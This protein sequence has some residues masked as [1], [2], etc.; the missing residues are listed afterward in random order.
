MQY[1]WGSTVKKAGRGPCSYRLSLSVS[2][3][4]TKKFPLHG[5]I[6]DEEHGKAQ[7]TWTY[8][9]HRYV[10][11]YLITWPR[12]RKSYYNG[13]TMLNQ[14]STNLEFHK[15]EE[16]ILM[17][18]KHNLHL[19]LPCIKHCICYKEGICVS[20]NHKAHKGKGLI[21]THPPCVQ[22]WQQP[23]LIAGKSIDQIRIS[24]Q[25]IDHPFYDG[26]RS[27][28]DWEYCTDID[29]RDDSYYI[30]PNNCSCN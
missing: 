19:M 11:Y 18:D 7:Q 2:L 14:Y 22:C 20:V 3:I 26:K 9:A 29:A 8:L 27:M 6:S 1:D 17:I 25:S 10:F 24:N 13:L 4:S 16:Q 21:I 30:T 5:G 12:A 28:H 23:L 15:W